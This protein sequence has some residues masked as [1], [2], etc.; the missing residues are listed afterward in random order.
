MQAFRFETTLQDD[1]TITVSALPL[2]AGQR[3][4][5]IVLP[6]RE[7]THA[8]TRYPLRGTVY[9]FDRPTDPVA[10]EDWEVIR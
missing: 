4:E 9:R 6:A 8:D 3:V 5:V 7:P 1:G 2:S 10:D